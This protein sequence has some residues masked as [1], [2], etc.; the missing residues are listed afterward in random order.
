M[1]R[2][3]RGAGSMAR[4]LKSLLV[5]VPRLQSRHTEDA[6]A[7]AGGRALRPLRASEWAASD[8]CDV[9]LVCGEDTRRD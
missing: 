3:G 4:H 1:E 6:D 2:N 7:R 5:F 8:A 9:R